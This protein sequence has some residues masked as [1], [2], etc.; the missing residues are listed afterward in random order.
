MLSEA[1]RK[2]FVLV[3]KFMATLSFF[4]SGVIAG[5]ILRR[6][7]YH[8]LQLTPRH[9][10][11]VGMSICDM[12]SSFA[13]F[14]ASWAI[15]AEISNVSWNKG[16]WA[17]CEAQG[18]FIQ[19][20][21]GTI[22]YNMS[23]SLYYL[24]VIRNSWTE[25]RVSR[26]VEPWMHTLPWALAVGTGSAGIA[27]DIYN[28]SGAGWECWIASFPAGCEQSFQD[29]GLTT[30][31]RG[32]DSNFYAYMFFYVPLWIA[33]IFVTVTMLMVYLKMRALEKAASRFQ[34]GGGQ[35]RRFAMQALL[36]EFYVS[37]LDCNVVISCHSALPILLTC[38]FTFLVILQ[39]WAH[40]I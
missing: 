10:L 20:S 16:N 15:P 22:A 40:S 17:T 37:V 31:E 30:C 39:T 8:R 7:K 5:D 33:I 21:L 18:F 35:T 24:L 14:I 6:W 36:C 27:L 38:L 2:A 4:G 11:L 34:Q 26:R 23:L 9:R 3:P 13:W 25:E 19:W 28:P 32:E 29:D 12:F 1:Q